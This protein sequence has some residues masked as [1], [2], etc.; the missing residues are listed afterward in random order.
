[1]AKKTNIKKNTKTKLKPTPVTGMD[2]V[3]YVAI[4]VVLGPFGILW[5]IYDFN[6][7]HAGYK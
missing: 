6:K 2:V 1:M 7:Y 4:C 5:A 3:W